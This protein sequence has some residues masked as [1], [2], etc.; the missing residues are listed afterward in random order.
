VSGFAAFTTRLAVKTWSS[1]DDDEFMSDGVVTEMRETWLDL[2][3]AAGRAGVSRDQLID[4]IT[5]RQIRATT[6]HPGRQ[7]DWMVPRRDIDRWAARAR[8]RRAWA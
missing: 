7:G 2:D 6:F 1:R 8:P 5:V 3:R 4:A